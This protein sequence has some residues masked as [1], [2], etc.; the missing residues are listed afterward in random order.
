MSEVIIN[1]KTIIKKL[2]DI[3]QCD[4]CK[5]IFDFNN[6]LPLITK[7]GETYCKH[8]ITN[9]KDKISV[10]NAK[11]SNNF[12]EFSSESNFIENLKIKTIIKEILNIY[13]K[14]INEKYVV[15]PKQITER[16]KNHRFGH[17]LLTYNNSTS[18]LRDN[19]VKEFVYENSSKKIH[20]QKISSLNNSKIINNEKLLSNNKSINKNEKTENIRYIDN[21]SDESKKNTKDISQ[22]NSI[23][24]NNNNNNI[25]NIKNENNV[26]NDDFEGNLNT[27]VFS[28]ETK[29][30]NNCFGTNDNN[31]IKNIDDDSIDTI[32][33]NDEKSMA[34][35]SFKNE[36]NEFWL[37]NDELH[38]E[39][40][41]QKEIKN[42]INK[43][44]FI[45]KNNLIYK[46]NQKMS[47]PFLNPRKRNET[48]DKDLKRN[49]DEKK[50]I[51]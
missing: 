31:N 20:N 40:V 1:V 12:D 35:I 27:L 51:F 29:I 19:N 3:L 15:F 38:N 50:K 14:T 36:F 49:E 8:C 5:N 7:T 44:V 32:P 47:G 16:N 18:N 17:Y 2:K 9:N 24:N 21:N 45:N 23:N 6:H 13:D 25:N 39:L 26:C 46:N 22:K 33:I 37:K 28:D 11:N 43:Y 10:K 34:N 30:N 41:N 42:E 48:K 4:L